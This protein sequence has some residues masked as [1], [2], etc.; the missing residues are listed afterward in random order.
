MITVSQIIAS[1]P[2]A[3]VFADDLGLKWRSHAR[4]MKIRGSIP[5]AYWPKVVAAAKKRGFPGITFETLAKAN[6]TSRKSTSSTSAQEQ[7]A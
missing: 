5:S 1:W 2:S 4:V 6:E 7:V 3:E